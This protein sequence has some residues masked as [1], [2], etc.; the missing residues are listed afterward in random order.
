MT[1]EHGIPLLFRHF[2]DGIAAAQPR[3]VYKDVEAAEASESRGNNLRRTVLLHQIV[4][5]AHCLVPESANLLRDDLCGRRTSGVDA[6]IAHHKFGAG[7]RQTV[8]LHSAD[9]ASCAGD[10]GY[11]SVQS[12]WVH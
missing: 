2:M 6:E 5:A 12:P 7:T 10:D 9:A 4:S 8:C 3:V 1:V 11:L